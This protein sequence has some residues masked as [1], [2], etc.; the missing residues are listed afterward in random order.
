[1]FSI[2]DYLN[3]PYSFDFFEAHV[4]GE[5]FRVRRMDGKER[6]VFNSLEQPYARV[7]FLLSQC[8]MDGAT[9]R[10]IGDTNAEMFI[11]RF[12][13]LATKLGG[14]IIR[15]NDEAAEQEFEAIENAEKNSVSAAGNGDTV[16]T[17]AVTE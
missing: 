8:L 16:A 14:E 4:G 11:S 5:T 15:L 2:T 7:H 17:V 6:I 10:A 13:A 9:N 3:R 12:G 1:M